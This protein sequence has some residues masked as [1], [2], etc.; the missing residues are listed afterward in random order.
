MAAATAAAAAAA[1]AAVA[2]VAVSS[3]VPA[4]CFMCKIRLKGIQ[5]RQGGRQTTCT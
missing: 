4:L 3:L 5:T 2:A 1:A